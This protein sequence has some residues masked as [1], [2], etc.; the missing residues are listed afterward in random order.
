MVIKNSSVEKSPLSFET[1]ACRDMSWGAEELNGVGNC[2]TMA[3]NRIRRCKE[4]F[5]CGLK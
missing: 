4:D 2:R 5:I 3:R 1:P